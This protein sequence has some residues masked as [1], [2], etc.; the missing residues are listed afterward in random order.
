[1]SKKINTEPTLLIQKQ[2]QSGLLSRYPLLSSTT[3][4]AS[5]DEKVK[6]TKVDSEINSFVEHKKQKVDLV[7]KEID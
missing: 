4:D 7:K 2:I 1:M 3:V 6:A 5:A